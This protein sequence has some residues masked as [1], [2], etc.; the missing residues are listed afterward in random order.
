MYEITNTYQ[1]T[2]LCCTLDTW[3]WCIL[4]Q[5]KNYCDLL[6]AFAFQLS[7]TVCILSPEMR[8]STADPV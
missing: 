3:A 7:P 2:P 1:S 4:Q 5:G 8:K 6:M